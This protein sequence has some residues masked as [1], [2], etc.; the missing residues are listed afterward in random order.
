MSSVTREGA[1]AGEPSFVEFVALIALMMSL[2]AM[3]IDNLLPAFGYIASDFRLADPNR[4]QLVVAV[5]MIGFGLMQ[6]VYGP[7]SDIIGRRPSVLLGLAIY[8]VG[9]L[10]AVFVGSF[11]AVLVAR[12]VQGMG[13]ASVRVL[14][15]AIVRDRFDGREMA[16]VMSFSMMIFLII[17][18]VAPSLGAVTLLFGSWHLI[19][20]S[21]LALCLIIAVWFSLRMPETLAPERRLPFSVRGILDGMK[22]C[23]T[24][25]VAFGYSTAM[26]LM[27]GALMGYISSAQQIFETDVYALGPIFT[28]VF[29]A[30]AA[31]M[32]VASFLNARLVRQLGMRRISHTGIIGFAIF[33]LIQVLLALVFDGKPPFLLF[34]AALAAN[35]FLFAL[36][37]GNFS[38][39]SMEPLGR[40][41]GTASS[42]IG[43]YTT[44]LGAAIGTVVG[45][46]FDGTVL[47]LGLGYFF[48]GAAGLAVVWWTE[49]YRL[50]VPHNPD[51]AR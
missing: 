10:M 20:L 37:V 8:A 31:L 38:A 4:A 50:F 19:F 46:A 33:G 6:L 36:T 28:A 15:P 24:N 27:M 39:M 40:V 11:E 9:S 12:F 7:L 17:P 2:A 22:L 25:R 43:F 26:A 5:Y 34:A 44:L 18:I 41:A 42:F 49:R 35:Q 14:A 23:L 45:Q 51:P 16:R 32:A 3:S 47:P 30:I 48:C 21:M 13:V 1:R 29:G